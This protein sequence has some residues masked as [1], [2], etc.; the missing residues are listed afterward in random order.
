MTVIGIKL[1]LIQEGP[2]QFVAPLIT[3]M[4]SQIYAFMIVL[5]C[6]SLIGT[7]GM[8]LPANT[9]DAV[10]FT[11]YRA[12][13]LLFGLV[14][15]V[16]GAF[17]VTGSMVWPAMLDKE[18]NSIESGRSKSG[19]DSYVHTMFIMPLHFFR[20]AEKPVGSTLVVLGVWYLLFFAML[21]PEI[22]QRF[23]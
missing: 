13:F 22:V 8:F 12:F 23:R 7:V 15:L 11:L 21:I 17:G 20:L 6:R 5:T 10:G 2:K 19:L 1:G 4:M 18:S 14:M 3:T 16:V 9:L